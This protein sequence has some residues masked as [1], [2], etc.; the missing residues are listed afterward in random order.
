MR[1]RLIQNEG[2][3]QIRG[4]PRFLSSHGRVKSIDQ[5][6]VLLKSRFSGSAGASSPVALGLQLV[7]PFAYIR[8]TT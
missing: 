1:L 7:G 6:P 8:P 4:I 3:N 5:D 2:N